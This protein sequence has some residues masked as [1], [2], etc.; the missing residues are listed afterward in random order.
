MKL[1][2]FNTILGNKLLIFFKLNLIYNLIYSFKVVVYKSYIIITS[3]FKFYIFI[4]FDIL[5]YDEVK[6]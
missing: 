5:I 2:L 4:I 3:F 1:Y 6:K